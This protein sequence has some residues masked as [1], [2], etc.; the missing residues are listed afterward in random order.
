MT[1][2]KTSQESDIIKSSLLNDSLGHDLGDLLLIE[3]AQRIVECTRS[4]DTVAEGV[5]TEKQLNFLKKNNC[6]A[7]QGYLFA[8]P[9]PLEEFERK[10]INLIPGYQFHHYV[11]D[12]GFTG[13]ALLLLSIRIIKNSLV[14]ISSLAV[15][16]R[17]SG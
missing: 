2:K 17:Y 16:E 11:E 4:E 6:H 5:E 15:I 12:G 7:F 14:K 3:V 8:R 13:V 10:V 9:L 1:D